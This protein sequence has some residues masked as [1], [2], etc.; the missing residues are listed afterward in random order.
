PIRDFFAQY[1]DFIYDPD[2]PFF[3]E[4]QRMQRVLHWQREERDAAREELRSAMVKQFNDM[5]G[6]NVDDLESW[7]LLCTALGM[8][9]PPA[10][11]ET[12]QKKVKATHVN[13]VDFIEAPLLG[14]SIE[15]FT[16]ELALSEYTKRTM[17][18]FPRYDVNS[19]SLLQFLLRQIKNPSMYRRGADS[20]RGGRARGRATARR[21]RAAAP[22]A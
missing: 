22:P 14:E 15:T 8:K 1:P 2:A 5:Y 11:V 10:D 20:T 4:F 13:L 16:S 12:C 6:T 7:Q 18:Y 9:P 19:G 3:E 17:K 21:G